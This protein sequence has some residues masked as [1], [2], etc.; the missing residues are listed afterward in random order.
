MKAFIVLGV[1]LLFVLISGCVHPSLLPDCEENS[2]CE[3]RGICVSSACDDG[4]CVYTQLEQSF[5]CS[6]Q[7]TEECDNTTKRTKSYYCEEAEC[8]YEVLI[9][10]DNFDCGYSMPCDEEACSLKT[11]WDCDVTTKITDLF[12]C[13]DFG[14]CVNETVKEPDHFDCRQDRCIGVRTAGLFFSCY[15]SEYMFKIDENS[16]VDFCLEITNE[17]YFAK[18]LSKLAFEKSDPAICD[19]DIVLFT[20]YEQ[21]LDPVSAADSCYFHY[22]YKYYPHID[23]DEWTVY[24]GK[25]ENSNLKDMCLRNSRVLDDPENPDKQISIY[26]PTYRPDIG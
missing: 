21:I 1:L 6:S 24:C 10:K 3:N 5:A 8:V 20:K 23:Q 22:F 18:C 15:E 17:Y 19:T 13:D 12:H 25:I 2:D 4:D 11:T 9:E 7:T 16:T 14:E 26:A